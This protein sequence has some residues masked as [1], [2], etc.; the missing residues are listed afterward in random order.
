M[1]LGGCSAGVV[2]VVVVVLGGACSSHDR[3]GTP[4]LRN[5]VTTPSAAGLPCAL[6]SRDDSRPVLLLLLLL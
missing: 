2:S 4:T 5:L 3:F 6:V 1:H